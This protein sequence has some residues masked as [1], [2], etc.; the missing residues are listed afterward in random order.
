MGIHIGLITGK[1]WYTFNFLKKPQYAG[2]FAG[3]ELPKVQGQENIYSLLRKNAPWA[4]AL[5]QEVRAF[6]LQLVSGESEE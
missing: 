4:E 3:T 5:I 1:G 2:L 6:A